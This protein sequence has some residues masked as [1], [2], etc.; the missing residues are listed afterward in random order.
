MRVSLK[1]SFICSKTVAACMADAL[2]QGAVA[3]DAPLLRNPPL[4]S[5]PPPQPGAR[6]EKALPL[7]QLRLSDLNQLAEIVQAVGHSAVPQEDVAGAETEPAADD[8]DNSPAAE[9]NAPQPSAKRNRRD[10]SVAGFIYIGLCACS[11][12]QA[13]MC[14]RAANTMWTAALCT[15]HF[16]QVACGSVRS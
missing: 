11:L 5:Q 4:T 15:G 6:R 14:I 1:N 9:D 2:S 10:S 3:A 8:D 7:V 16:V 12:I 13:R